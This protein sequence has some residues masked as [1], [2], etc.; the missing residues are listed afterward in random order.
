MSFVVISGQESTFVV[1]A[2]NG[3]IAGTKNQIP[4]GTPDCT[5]PMPPAIVTF[6]TQPYV[7]GS[8]PLCCKKRALTV[9]RLA[10]LQDVQAVLVIDMVRELENLVVV[11]GIPKPEDAPGKG[12]LKFPGAVELKA[13]EGI[14]STKHTL[15]PIKDLQE[16]R[17]EGI[18][19]E[20]EFYRR[21][22]F[23][24]YEDMGEK[25][26]IQQPI[27]SDLSPKVIQ[28]YGKRL[29]SNPVFSDEDSH[30]N[31]EED[32]YQNG[33]KDGKVS[34]ILK[35]KP[36]QPTKLEPIK[37][38]PSAKIKDTV[39]IEYEEDSYSEEEEENSK[40]PKFT[41]LDSLKQA[42][43]VPIGWIPKDTQ[44]VKE[45]LLNIALKTKDK[46]LASKRKAIALSVQTIN[47]VSAVGEYFKGVSLPER[48]IILTYF[49]K[50]CQRVQ[51][52]LMA[53][54]DMV[55]KP[56]K[57]KSPRMKK[58]VLLERARNAD[59]RT[60]V[61]VLLQIIRDLAEYIEPTV[62]NG[63]PDQK[64][65]LEIM[66][67]D[68]KNI[69]E[70]KKDPV[71]EQKTEEEKKFEVETEE[72]M[73]TLDGG[74]HS[75]PQRW[76]TQWYKDSNG[77]FPIYSAP[78]GGCTWHVIAT[79]EANKDKEY[80]DI[81][82]VVNL[83]KLGRDN[84]VQAESY[85]KKIYELGVFYASCMD[86]VWRGYPPKN[87]NR[88]F[89]GW[90]VW[91]IS[92]KGQGH[93]GFASFSGMDHTAM[94][95]Y[96]KL[97]APRY[98]GDHNQM[99]ILPRSKQ[100]PIR[101]G[102]KKRDKGYKKYQPNKMKKRD[103]DEESEEDVIWR[104]VD[105]PKSDDEDK[106]EKQSEDR[107][108]EDTKYRVKKQPVKTGI[109]NSKAAQGQIIGP[110]MGRY[111]NF[112]LVNSETK[113][114]KGFIETMK[115]HS[116]W[117]INKITLWKAALSAAAIY[118]FDLWQ[119]GNLPDLEN[120]NGIN[121][122]A[123]MS[124]CKK[125]IK[126]EEIEA[127]IHMFDDLEGF[128]GWSE[129]LLNLLM[130][131]ERTAAN[132]SL[133]SK[134]KV[135]E[136]GTHVV[137]TVM[138][139]GKMTSSSLA[140][141]QN[142]RKP[143]YAIEDEEAHQLAM[144]YFHREGNKITHAVPK[145]RLP[146]SFLPTAELMALPK[147]LHDALFKKR[148][149]EFKRSTKP[150][151]HPV[152]RYVSDHMRIPAFKALS[153]LVESR[154]H[155]VICSIGGYYRD[156]LKN[157]KDVV[158]AYPE[159]ITYVCF[160]PE[161]T[162][163]DKCYNATLE[164]NAWFTEY[165]DGTEIS[166]Y[167]RRRPWRAED[168]IMDSTPSEWCERMNINVPEDS[169]WWST[170][171]DVVYYLEVIPT[172]CHITMLD[173]SRTHREYGTGRNYELPFGE[174]FIDYVN[175]G[176]YLEVIQRMNG[177]QKY[178]H[179]I[180][181][182]E[183]SGIEPVQT[184]PI[185]FDFEH[186]YFQTP[187]A[188]IPSVIVYIP[189]APKHLLDS[190]SIAKASSTPGMGGNGVG[191]W[192]SPLKTIEK[193][194]ADNGYVEILEKAEHYLT[195]DVVVNGEVWIDIRGWFSMI[196]TMLFTW[197]IS[198]IF[199][200]YNIVLITISVS[201]SKV[202]TEFYSG[203]LLY[204]SVSVYVSTRMPAPISLIGTASLTFYLAAMS[205][206]PYIPAIQTN[207]NR[208]FTNS[209][210]WYKSPREKYYRILNAL[211][212]EQKTVVNGN[213]EFKYFRAPDPNTLNW[214]GNHN[215]R[216]I[217]FFIKGVS[218]T[219]DQ[220]VEWLKAFRTKA[221]RAIRSGLRFSGVYEYEVNARH[222]INLFSAFLN[223]HC[224]TQLQP[225]D[226]VISKFRQWNRRRNPILQDH[227]YKIEESFE[228]W[229]KRQKHWS[230]SKKKKY[231]RVADQQ[232]LGLHMSRIR[233]NCFTKSGEVNLS[234]QLTSVCDHVAR[235]ICAPCDDMLGWPVW[236]A[237]Q[238]IKA[239][240]SK[241]T[242][243]VHGMNATEMARLFQ[244]VAEGMLDPVSIS[245]DGSRHDAHQHYK[246]I[247]SVQGTFWEKNIHSIQEYVDDQ[248]ITDWVH[249]VATNVDNQI[250]GYVG[251]PIRSN[252]YF[253]AFVKGTTT[254]GNA[255]Q[256][257]LGNGLN[258]ISMFDWTWFETCQEL[259]IPWKSITEEGSP[260][261][262]FVSGDDSFFLIERRYSEAF[263]RKICEF[264]STVKKGIKGLGQCIKTV[265]IREWWQVDF[266][267]KLGFLDSG[268]LV[269]TRSSSSLLL[270]SN[271]YT[272]T[273]RSLCE[274]PASH[275][276]LVAM[277]VKNEA[278]SLLHDAVAETRFRLGKNSTNFKENALELLTLFGIR[279][280]KLDIVDRYNHLE[281]IFSASTEFEW[282]QNDVTSILS[283]LKNFT[284]GST[285]YL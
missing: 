29:M 263:R 133:G 189:A 150:C 252:L 34:N 240:K 143:T 215:L 114:M 177:S 93:T 176:A 26:R 90:F 171:F 111:V 165:E 32:D 91:M 236:A 277:S 146:T 125:Y 197:H 269:L 54:F 136:R 138:V 85:R 43:K 226:E 158:G 186:I 193:V 229:I 86:G 59:S 14:K 180:I 235:F 94:T 270:K 42:I 105:E 126:V 115:S 107:F 234:K 268:K 230:A 182:T 274:D 220:I 87:L 12:F 120:P 122:I 198:Y 251:A 144:G 217:E 207:V 209:L 261:R 212:E 151:L 276:T 140:M 181:D 200:L 55:F 154:K 23:F 65:F 97:G 83:S 190:L 168:D 4:E 121:R 205:I 213:S 135:V 233:Y 79:I 281:Y 24:T 76:T 194:L 159:G 137:T 184:L 88:F 148:P 63:K 257:T 219:P 237:S 201:L 273:Q 77:E 9:A 152:H 164:N 225:D 19:T 102:E 30:L 7:K 80:G 10:N 84:G 16:F 284:T 192:A 248:K 249:K 149:A 3:T 202:W 53:C 127:R 95:I 71:E 169:I 75:E 256:T 33:L 68:I 129:S 175:N 48:E 227:G 28:S 118:V 250:Y 145:T 58:E 283:Q 47:L 38:K 264:T 139:N 258:V 72:R 104:R 253:H 161:I 196:M 285:L 51:D 223:R 267:S 167:I 255:P 170:C 100:E 96:T 103:M 210:S 157:I 178:Q 116:D 73:T 108:K 280:S 245:M 259:G 142:Y 232:K 6:G 109:R 81:E 216:S 113:T 99:F 188:N 199:V 31:P 18:Q 110:V 5:H 74:V 124:A 195:D 20:T 241:T 204:V 49:K 166:V 275:Q 183:S 162:S 163:S 242:S 89:E 128:G 272:G 244:E 130:N 70:W 40:T 41:L 228:D 11:N 265:D 187:K 92:E 260:C 21:P 231:Q 8:A 160:R 57:A 278:K 185:S 82:A 147:D 52:F 156:E 37:K 39:R 191:Y 174:G 35:T 44:A 27:L 46:V 254:S 282:H 247:Q 60:Q 69:G 22:D 2:T 78:D 206:M 123:M 50:T 155:I 25:S 15:D 179:R 222:P 132:L 13:A 66:I 134:I 266:L 238:M 271:M 211:R 17:K 112:I 98:M 153:A 172:Q 224:E 106:K 214:K 62:V 56:K 279:P 239:V 64:D 173:Y 101:H 36:A 246:I 119:S 262:G 221:G 61:S 203:H 1:V 131:V 218:S 243:F 117:K 45:V 208:F 141:M 67:E